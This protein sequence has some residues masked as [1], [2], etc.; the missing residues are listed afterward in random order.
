MQPHK[1]LSLCKDE[2]KVMTRIVALGLME[3]F[4]DKREACKYSGHPRANLSIIVW[5]TKSTLSAA[6]HHK[7]YYDPTTD[8][9]MKMNNEKF[10]LMRYGPLD[11]TKQSTSYQAHHQNIAPKQHVRHLGVTMSADGPQK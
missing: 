10:E 9:N 11:G 1:P 8:T 6:T 3:L 2:S 4:L 7:L 5:G